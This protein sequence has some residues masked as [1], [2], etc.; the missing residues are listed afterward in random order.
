[1]ACCV[2]C[3]TPLRVLGVERQRSGKLNGLRQSDAV[4]RFAPAYVNRLP[5]AVGQPPPHAKQH[6]SAHPHPRAPH[7]VASH[8]IA[9]PTHG[10]VA[11]PT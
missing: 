2:R 8:P 11:A 9:D 1:M 4:V 6:A 5:V 3:V 10:A 7:P